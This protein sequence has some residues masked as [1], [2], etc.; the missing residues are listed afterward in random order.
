MIEQIY[1]VLRP[2]ICKEGEYAVGDEILCD[3]EN[4][5]LVRMLLHEGAIAPIPE[6]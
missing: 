3:A 6:A 4:L 1:V 2:F 5:S